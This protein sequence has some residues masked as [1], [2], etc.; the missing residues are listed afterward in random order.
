MGI[1]QI[2]LYA[3]NDEILSCEESI[4]INFNNIP[5][6]LTAISYSITSELL[7]GV[8]FVS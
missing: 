5:S 1:F 6:A 4:F 8:G 3:K 2:K 7:V